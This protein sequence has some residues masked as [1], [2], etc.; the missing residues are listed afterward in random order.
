MRKL[1]TYLIGRVAPYSIYIKIAIGAAVIGIVLGWHARGTYERA[2]DNAALERQID[3]HLED[4]TNSWLAGMGLEGGLGQYKVAVEP[5]DRK[6]NNATL[7]DSGNRFTADIVQ[8]T[9]ERI[10][11]GESARKRAYPL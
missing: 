3:E 7:H 11:A 4:E 9:Q 1:F 8:R 5:I 2:K 10:A 6:V